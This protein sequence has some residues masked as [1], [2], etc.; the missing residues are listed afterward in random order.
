MEK[1]L[2]IDIRDRYLKIDGI[3]TL[4]GEINEIVLDLS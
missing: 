1:H 4:R 2:A 3:G